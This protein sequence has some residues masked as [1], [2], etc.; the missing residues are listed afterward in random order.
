MNKDPEILAAKLRRVHDTHVRPL[1]SLVE[2]WR[3][4]GRDVPW[5]GPNLGGVHSL[6]LHES[7]GPAS[8]A[9]HGSGIISPDKQRPDRSTVL[10][11][12]RDC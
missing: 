5:A 8:S 2:Q 3:R 9:G 1:N 4:E 6:F 12:R 7:P 11:P 10:A